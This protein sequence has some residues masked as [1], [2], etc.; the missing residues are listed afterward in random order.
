MLATLYN[1]SRVTI[2]LLSD[3]LP[4]HAAE[5]FGFEDQVQQFPELS[6]SDEIVQFGH[7]RGHSRPAGSAVG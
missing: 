1:Y 6:R 4:P 5:Q 7:R 3:R 2:F